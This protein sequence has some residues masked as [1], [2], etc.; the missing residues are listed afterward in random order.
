MSWT[1]DSDVTAD[2]SLF[3]ASGS[4]PTT[5]PT[6]PALP[7]V[8]NLVRAE[9]AASVAAGASIS[10]ELQALSAQLGLPPISFG[11]G[12]DFSSL[13]LKPL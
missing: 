5:F 8:P 11:P 12:A 13:Q 6:V 2:S 7:G 10:G 9:T 1:A 4:G 3:T